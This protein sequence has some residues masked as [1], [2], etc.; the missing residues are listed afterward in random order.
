V[1]ELV[2]AVGRD[3]AV[4]GWV[5]M[6]FAECCSLCG[7]SNFM[8]MLY[9]DPKLAH[10][11]LG[12]VT[13]IVI[14]FALAQMEAG[15]PKIGAGDAATS[16]ISPDLYREFARPYERIICEAVHAHGGLVKLHICGNT[17]RLLKDITK[18]GADLFNV[19]H[20]VELGL[21]AGI[22]G[23]AGMAFKGNLDPVADMLQSDPGRCR[24]KAMRCIEAAG[25]TRYMLSAGCEV[26]AAVTDAVFE[27]F[28]SAAIP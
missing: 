20:M 17:T 10:D 15:A 12:F 24:A 6:P 8:M 2:K 7:V 21:A 19:D 4:L 23:E 13:D 16:M 3:L 1:S 28:C 9:D 11:L 14:D 18:S 25:S 27:A 22:Y 26:P 5:D